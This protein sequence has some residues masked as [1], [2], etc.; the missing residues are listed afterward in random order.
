MLARGDPVVIGTVVP[1]AIPSD[2]LVTLPRSAAVRPRQPE[3]AYTLE[4]GLCLTSRGKTIA[5]V[6]RRF[7][8]AGLRARFLGAKQRGAEHCGERE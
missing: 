7:R 8:S 3:E 4:P 5:A 2:S 1:D 6:G